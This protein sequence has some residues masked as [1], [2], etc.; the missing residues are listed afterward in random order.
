[1]IDMQPEPDLDLVAGRAYDLTERIRQED[2]RRVHAELSNLCRLHP[3]KAAQMMMALAVWINP[4]DGTLTLIQRAENV[5][6]CRVTNGAQQ[7]LA[8]TG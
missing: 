4:D 6:R 5:T 8:V 2:P 1:M 7:Q 3:A